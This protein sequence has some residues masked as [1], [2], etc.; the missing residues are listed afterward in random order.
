MSVCGEGDL[1]GL[2]RSAGQQRRR[3]SLPEFGKDA[4]VTPNAQEYTDLYAKK[5]K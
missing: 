5:G 1:A 2:R 4:F 3:V